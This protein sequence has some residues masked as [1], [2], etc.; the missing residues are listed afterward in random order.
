MSASGIL[1]IALGLCAAIVAWL[2]AGPRL[3][4][5]RDRRTAARPFPEPWERALHASMPA[6]R[7]LPERLRP[8]LRRRIQVFL[9][10]KHFVA[11]AGMR[12]DD[13]V[14]V[15]IAA[16]ACLLIVN[17]PGRPYAAVRDIVV[18][19]GAFATW[20][21]GIDAAGVHGRQRQ[22]LA[23]ESWRAGRVMLAWQ[24][25]ERMD[26]RHNVVVHE[27]AHQLDDEFPDAPGAPRLAHAAEY[28][29]WA[30][31]LG[32]EY[33]ALETAVAEGRS[34][35][36][37]PYG[38]V[39]PAEFFAVASELF[40]QDPAALRARHPELYRA[41]RRYYRLDPAAWRGRS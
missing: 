33:R 31:V 7:R 13:R 23:G 36:I 41:L 25:V 6:Y 24:E 21:E 30:R 18:F 1:A 5:W 26:C 15:L 9:A 12:I 39:G 38:A 37:D 14:R 27:F 34:T 28:R 29:R 16:Y 17:R 20:R 11:A 10:R 35:L 22:V 8:R 19:P 32:A 2:L 40:I 3:Q 4:T